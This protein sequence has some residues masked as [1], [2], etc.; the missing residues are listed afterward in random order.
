MGKATG[1]AQA[2][3]HLRGVLPGIQAITVP[4][5]TFLIGRV[6]EYMDETGNLNEET[7]ANP[8]GPDFALHETLASTKWYS[9]ALAAARDKSP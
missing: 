3:S 7:K 5:A 1:G 2:V 4:S 8:H 9:D 6:A